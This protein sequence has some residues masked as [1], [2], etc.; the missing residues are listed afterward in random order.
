[1]TRLMLNI[2]VVLALALTV[3]AC[4]WIESLSSPTGPSEVG[5]KPPTGGETVYEIANN[6]LNVKFWYV[7]EPARDSVVEPGQQFWLTVRCR[8]TG[9]TFDWRMSLDLEFI[10][11]DGARVKGIV[12]DP[13]FSVCGDPE[14][15]SKSGFRFS[16]SIREI[17]TNGWLIPK[18]VADSEQIFSWRE[19]TQPGVTG[20]ELVNYD[21]NGS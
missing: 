18:N 14:Q 12:K 10:S 1:M 2:A 21:M 11:P 17:R 8:Y 15:T 13:N 20:A 7:L 5:F 6:D 16:G 3:S 4:G 9:S 19:N